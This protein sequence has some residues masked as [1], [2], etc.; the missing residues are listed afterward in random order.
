MVILPKEIYMFNI[1]PINIPMT[2]ITEVE[3][4]HPK[5][6][7]EKQDTMNSQGNTDQKEQML[8]VS[9]YLTSNYTTEP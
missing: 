5:V 1:I 7:L 6:H 8:E 2:F 9:Q 4:I 3:K